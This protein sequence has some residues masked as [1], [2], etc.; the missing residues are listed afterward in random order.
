M[1]SW[2]PPS[3]PRVYCDNIIVSVI[4]ASTS[5]LSK[6]NSFFIAPST[7]TSVLVLQCSSIQWT[8]PM[9]KIQDKNNQMYILVNDK[10][11]IVKKTTNSYHLQ[12]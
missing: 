11:Q 5:L 1:Y 10:V 6:K 4:T 9:H 7:L 12:C 8:V 3:E 2:A